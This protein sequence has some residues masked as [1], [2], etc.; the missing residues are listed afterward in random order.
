MQSHSYKFIEFFIAFIVV[1]VSFVLDYSIL[2]KFLIGIVGF[3]YIIFVLL[4][5]E[6]NQFKIAKNLNWKLF[7]KQTMLKFVA[8]IVLTTVYVC[9]YDQSN[10]F[11][12]V[13]NK[14]FLW[15][16]IIFAY[17]LFSV[18]PQELIYR[19]FYFQRYQALFKSPKTLIFINA[20]LFCLAH[21]FFRNTLVL[22]LT[23][24]GGVLFG[25]TFYKTKSTLLVTVEHAIYGSWLFT[26]GMGEM[27][28]FP[29]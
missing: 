18:Y 13:L 5:I 27:L 12:V 4:R 16:A 2:I 29:S 26:V 7:W 24:L 3:I 28:G 19:T 25:F 1:P 17:S 8:V 20:I 11:A 9:I 14:P 15:F 23:F 22:V 21:L 10:L 6:N